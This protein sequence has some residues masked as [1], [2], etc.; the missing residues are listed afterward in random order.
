VFAELEREILRAF[1]A[2]VEWVEAHP[3]G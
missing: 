1:D 2:I 3:T